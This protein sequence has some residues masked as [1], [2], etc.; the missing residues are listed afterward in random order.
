M[1]SLSVHVNRNYS[2]FLEDYPECIHMKAVVHAT[3][4]WDAIHSLSPAQYFEGTYHPINVMII[5]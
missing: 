5:V 1:T 2:E 4:T 3:S